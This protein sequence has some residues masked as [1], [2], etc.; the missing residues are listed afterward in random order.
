MIFNTLAFAKF[1]VVVFVATWALTRWPKARFYLLTA[2]SY[3]FYAGLDLFTAAFWEAAKTIGPWE[4]LK[5]NAPLL[6]FVPI[7]FI[8]S[9]V[10]YYLSIWIANTQDDKR[11]KHLV[12]V[13]IAMNTGLLLVFKY[14]DFLAEQVMAL[15]GGDHRLNLPLPVGISFFTFM[16]LSYVVDV[17]RREIPASRSY[18]HYI[19]YIAFFP[20]LVAGPIIRGKDLLPL[21]AKP[22]QLTAHAASE[23][24]FLVSIGLFKKVVVSD[25]LRIN[26]VDRVVAEPTSYSSLEVLVGMFGYAIQIYC[27]FSGYSDVAIGVALLLGYRL[28]INFDAPF[29]ASNLVEFWRRWHISLSSWLRDYIYIPLGGSRIVRS[30]APAVAS[31]RRAISKVLL[32]VGVAGTVWRAVHA[33][34]DSDPV[35][36]TKNLLLFLGA[37]ALLLLALYLADQGRKYV[38]VW[39]TMVVCGIWHGAAWSY[40]LFG[41]VQGLAVGVTHYYFDWRGVRPGDSGDAGLSPKKLVS[42]AVCFVFTTFTFVLIRAPLDKALLIY[43]QLFQLSTYTP[44]LTKTLLLFIFGGLVLQWM[45]RKAYDGARGLFMRAPA[46]VQA[47]ALFVL[48]IALREAASAEALPFVYGQF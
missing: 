31:R 19:T 3:V 28:K 17:Y 45:P 21:F 48:A 20:H 1:F 41:V 46:P 44:N 5:A 36:K 37:S 2:A 16:S 7:V 42:V 27:D 18:S 29:K 39:V 47:V 33:V 9:T 12:Y 11:R 25:Y 15:G 26:L 8:G 4:A 38:N 24:M 32:V 34:H 43:K 23:G 40:V 35:N 22:V 14:W 10:D 13:T 30:E 6:E